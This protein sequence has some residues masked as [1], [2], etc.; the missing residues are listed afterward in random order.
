MNEQAKMYETEY[1]LID[2]RKI[3]YRKFGE[4]PPLLLIN[5]F[6]GTLDVWDPAFLEHLADSHTVITFDYPGI[7]YSE[8]ELPLT[9]KEV[10]AAVVKLADFLELKE[11]DVLGWS[12]GG[13][14][15]Q[16]VELIYPEK[17]RKAVLVG[18]NPPGKNEVPIE[19]VFMQTAFKPEY[20]LEDYTV[21]FFEPK[22]E[23]SRLAA[24]A[25]MERTYAHLDGSKVPMTEDVVQRYF[26]V[27]KEFPEDAE[28]L[29]SKLMSTDI[30][31]LI[32]SG[33][34]DIS[35][36]L[37]N[38]YPVIKGA[39]NLHLITFPEA[40]HGSHFQNPELAAGFIKTFLANP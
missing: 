31:T 32:I 6:R 10:A 15:A 12:Y 21:L 7:G 22:S 8:G 36:A 4:G 30:P 9:T 40:G 26:P 3:A 37:E 27:M 24:K 11:F 19:P 39:R 5:R 33:D 20:D 2:G 14:I 16:Y 25:S 18:T 34:H 1:A 13:L 29:R 23:K 17:V 35:F 38:W 28:D